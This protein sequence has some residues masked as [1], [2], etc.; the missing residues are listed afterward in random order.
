MTTLQVRIEPKL[1]KEAQKIAKSLGMDLSTAIKVFLMQMTVEK[2]MPF[3]PYTEH[4]F[5][6]AQERKIK[7]EVEEAM[8]YGKSYSSADE[9]FDDILGKGWDKKPQKNRPTKSSKRKRSAKT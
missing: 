9:L 2:A 5:S 6:P 3:C 7:K 1:K 4:R 8:L